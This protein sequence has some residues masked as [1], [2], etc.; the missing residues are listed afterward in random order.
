MLIIINQLIFIYIYIACG[1]II[2]QRIIVHGFHLRKLVFVFEGGIYGIKRN[3][4]IIILLVLFVLC[5]VYIMIC[6]RT[7]MYNN[8]EISCDSIPYTSFAVGIYGISDIILSLALNHMF[9][10]R[11]HVILSC[12]TNA[13][14]R[15]IASKVSI[16]CIVSIFSNIVFILVSSLISK[17]LTPYKIYGIDLIFSNF[18][19]LCQY[20]KTRNLYDILCPKKVFV[21]QTTSDIE[22]ATALS[23]VN[24]IQKEDIGIIESHSAVIESNNDS[25]SNNDLE[26]DIDIDK[27]PVILPPNVPKLGN[28]DISDVSRIIDNV[29]KL[30]ADDSIKTFINTF[31]KQSESKESESKES[32]S[33]ESES[34]TE[35][36]IE[37]N[38]PVSISVSIC[39]QRQIAAD[40]CINAIKKIGL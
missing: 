25:K 20:K 34:D 14:L 35:T 3:I 26:F 16:L 4:I 33:K 28:K 1:L 13:I 21:K 40:L 31:T 32:E 8:T 6:L 24:S 30:V 36:S 37:P 39:D 10:K 7:H 9:T 18:C 27:H 38:I 12:Q 29:P 11:I 17:T 5:S 19:I 23:I 2:L 22:T 15:N